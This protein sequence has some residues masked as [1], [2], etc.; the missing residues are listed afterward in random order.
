MQPW[1]RWRE[2]LAVVLLV[3]VGLMLVVRIAGLAVT[4]ASGGGVGYGAIPGGDDL[5]IVAAA[6]A[7][8]W[9]V[10][11]LRPGADAGTEGAEPTPSRRAR[12]VALVGVALIGATVLLWFVV[13][14]G[15]VVEL[16]SWPAREIGWVLLGADGVLRLV[17]PAVAL[18]A[19]VLASRRTHPAGRPAESPAVLTADADDPPAVTAAPERLP[20]AWQADEATGAVWLTAD[21]AA[22]GQPGLSWSNPTAA[23]A[24]ASG[25]WAPE[26]PTDSRPAGAPAPSATP[27]PAAGG[28]RSSGSWVQPP[29]PPARPADEW[30]RPARPPLAAEDDDLR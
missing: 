26:A 12:A 1:H 28:D 2:P 3:A 29:A 13:A 5:L 27:S 6:G 25:P 19:V 30:A 23:G 17:V 15:T 11:R 10:A 16:V 24:V 18:V 14:V 22:Q 7:V 20:A 21:D 9:C 4:I 8:V